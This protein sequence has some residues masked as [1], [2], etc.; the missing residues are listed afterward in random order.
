[1]STLLSCTTA[2]QSMV[3]TASFFSHLLDLNREVFSVS[4]KFK[5]ARCS[6]HDDWKCAEQS[7]DVFDGFQ[8]ARCRWMKR[9]HWSLKIWFRGKPWNE[10]PSIFELLLQ[11][12]FWGPPA[13]QNLPETL[14]FRVCICAL[15]SHSIAHE[16][17]TQPVTSQTYLAEYK[18]ADNF[19]QTRPIVNAKW[20]NLRYR[21]IK[22]LHMTMLEK[23][24]TTYLANKIETQNL[25]S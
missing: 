7:T 15:S 11:L 13:T 14:F 12:T 17:T 23:G 24:K 9:V 19:D 16:I 10:I 8:F 22:K 20:G 6:K 2:A 21:F 1:M 4:P 25:V 3:G 5:S 18:M